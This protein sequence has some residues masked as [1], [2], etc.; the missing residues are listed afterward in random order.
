MSKRVQGLLLSLSLIASATT[1]IAVAPSASA[2]APN[3]ASGYG[4]TVTGNRWI[5]ARTFEVDITRDEGGAVVVKAT[6]WQ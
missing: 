6:A 1:A 5:T 4:I 3:M 2:D